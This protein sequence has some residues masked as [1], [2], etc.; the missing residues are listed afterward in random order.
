MNNFLNTIFGSDYI[1]ESIAEL[2]TAIRE[3]VYS[4]DL[5]HISHDGDN[6]MYV[7]EDENGDIGSVECDVVNGIIVDIW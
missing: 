6:V 7:F 5:V 2:D 1:G 3:S 4:E